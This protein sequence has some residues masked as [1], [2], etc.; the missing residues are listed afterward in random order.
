M[1]PIEWIENK[2]AS[3]ASYAL[4]IGDENCCTRPSEGAMLVDNVKHVTCELCRAI[5]QV[6]QHLRMKAGNA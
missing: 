4:R 3:R 5:A 1:M 6:P 2:Q